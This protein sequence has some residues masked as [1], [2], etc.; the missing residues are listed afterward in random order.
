MML[1]PDGGTPLARIEDYLEVSAI[2]SHNVLL[3]TLVSN[4]RYRQ[5]QVGLLWQLSRGWIAFPLMAASAY[6]QLEKTKSVP[7]QADRL[8]AWWSQRGR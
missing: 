7:V 6:V 5:H 8:C 4:I 2:N 3:V 1:P